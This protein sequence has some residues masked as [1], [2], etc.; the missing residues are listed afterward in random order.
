NQKLL[1]NDIEFRVSLP[2]TKGWDV[3]ESVSLNIP[4]NKGSNSVKF[5]NQQSGKAGINN[6]C[7]MEMTSFSD[8]FVNNRPVTDARGWIPWLGIWSVH[9]GRYVPDKRK[10]SV[11]LLSYRFN[12]NFTNYTNVTLTSNIQ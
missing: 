6:I 9:E 10:E 11:S 3:V 4:L 7:I 2:A 1:V 5:I 12:G 8:D